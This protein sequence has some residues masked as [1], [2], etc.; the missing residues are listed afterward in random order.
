MKIVSLVLLLIPASV[1][2]F[3]SSNQKRALSTKLLMAPKFD[4]KTQRWTPS[5]DEEATPAYGPIGSLIRA[6][7]LPF[8]QRIVNADKY[9]QAVY[10]CE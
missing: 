8:I 1:L 9:E 4:V 5:S 6:G 2:S 3:S 7:P 10:K